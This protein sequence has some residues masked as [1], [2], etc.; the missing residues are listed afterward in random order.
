MGQWGQKHVTVDVLLHYR[1]SDELFAFVGLHRGKWIKMHGMEN[2]KNNHTGNV[3][4]TQQWGT[5]LLPLLQWKNNKYYIKWV[6]MCSLRYLARNAR[7]PYCYLCPA[8]LY[9]TF[10]HYL[11]N[12]KISGKTFLIIKC[13][14]WLS[15]QLHSA[16]YLVLRRPERDII[17]NVHWSSCK[18]PVILFRL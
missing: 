11:I 4:I 13:V 2:V 18:V 17:K 12:G 14:F 10:P 7:A 1:N 3:R 16:T 6:R 15:L 9:S 8:R 5:F